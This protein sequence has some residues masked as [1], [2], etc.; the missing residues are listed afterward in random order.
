MIKGTCNLIW[1]KGRRLLYEYVQ[2]SRDCHGRRVVA[3]KRRIILMAAL[4]ALTATA[5]TTNKLWLT[6]DNDPDYD[7]NV[8]FYVYSQTN[9]MM[10]LSGWTVATNVSYSQWTNNPGKLPGEIGVVELPHSLDRVRFYVVTAS[11]I[12]G[13]SDFSEAVSVRRTQPPGRVRIGVFYSP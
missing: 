2:R 9:A 4:L 13:E 6:W 11:N 8:T 5:A 3:T 7:T 1:R 10:I 12:F